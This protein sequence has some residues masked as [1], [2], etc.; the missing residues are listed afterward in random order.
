MI[1]KSILKSFL[2]LQAHT[3]TLS[4]LTLLM[5][6]SLKINWY[7]I[8]E[9]WIRGHG[10]ITLLDSVTEMTGP[11]DGQ[12][13]SP[14]N[15]GWGCAEAS[16]HNNKQQWSAWCSSQHLEDCETWIHVSST[17]NPCQREL[18]HFSLLLWNVLLKVFCSNTKQIVSQNISKALLGTALTDTALLCKVCANVHTLQYSPVNSCILATTTREQ[19][20]TNVGMVNY[21]N[22]YRGGPKDKAASV[23]SCVLK[24]SPVFKMSH[25][26]RSLQRFKVFLFLV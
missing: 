11:P 7:F 15:K 6:L 2:K 13:Q 23:Q 22:T 21:S 4:R 9:A 1:Q 5:G 24:D 10:N 3:L 25:N 20:V 18:L 14:S 16:C 8:S 17:F 12:K 26:Q 19:Q